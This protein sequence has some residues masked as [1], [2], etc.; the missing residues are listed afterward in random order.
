MLEKTRLQNSL[1]N[2][3]KASEFVDIIL[4]RYKEHGGSV[5][6]VKE[7]YQMLS[8]F[9]DH[10]TKKFLRQEIQFQKAMHSRDSQ[11]RPSL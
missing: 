7:L 3:Q 10:D 1:A 6:D 2:H 5:T 9:S 4:K 11:E 8:N